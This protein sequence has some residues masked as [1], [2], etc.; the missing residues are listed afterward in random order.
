MTSRVLLPL[1]ALLAACTATLYSTVQGASTAV[2]DDAYTC[3]QN[4]MKTLG[5][6]RTQYDAL[7]R[8]YVGQKEEVDPTVASGLYR[9]TVHVLDTKVRP[10]ASGSTAIE[11]T[12][13]TFEEYSN[14][15]GVDLQEKK[16]SALVKRDAQ[17]LVQ[18]CASAP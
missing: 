4:Q 14:Q 13:K 16:A 7:E 5:Y 1:A 12:A 3:V 6:R 15:R 18:A 17:T 2:P 9:K 11:I 8:W 10:D